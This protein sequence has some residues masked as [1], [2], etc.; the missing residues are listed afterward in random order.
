MNPN[1][2]LLLFDVDGTIAASGQQISDQMFDLF[3]KL[4]QNGFHLGIVGGGTYAKIIYQ[5]RDTNNLFEHIFSECGCIYHRNNYIITKKNIR[6][7]KYYFEINQIIKTGLEFLS[8]VDYTLTGNF[9]DLRT[10]IVYFSLIGMQANEFE[11]N[12][13]MS[14]DKEHNYRKNLIEIMRT[15]AKELGVMDKIDILEGGSVGISIYPSEWNKVQVIDKL[16]ETT[17]Y[18]NIHYFGDKYLPGENDHDL[19]NHPDIIGHRINSVNDTIHILQK[20]L[21][22]VNKS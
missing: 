17:N 1:S 14:L 11:R 2:I 15:K 19:I 18:T 4:H 12:K 21:D 6:D 7:H 20:L 3:Q 13:F 9:V 16:S 8:K 5:L 22:T 10:G